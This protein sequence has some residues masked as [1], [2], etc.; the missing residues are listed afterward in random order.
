VRDWRV[1]A[2]SRAVFQDRRPRALLRA[3]VRLAACAALSLV[4]APARA[5]SADELVRQA[6]AHEAAREHDVALRRYAEALAIDPTHPDAWLG[7]GALRLKLGEAAEAERVYAS[8]LERVPS[9]HRALEGRARARWALGRHAE[10]ESDLDAYAAGDGDVAALRELA[11]WYAADG[12]VAAQLATWR[13]VLALARAPGKPAT[14]DQGRGA[15]APG[16]ADAGLE[17]EARR[18]VQALV[19]LVDGADPASSP[20]DPDA[21]R[22]ALARIAL[23]G[24]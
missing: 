6:E 10:A 2:C 4:A 16:A 12:R 7:L 3:L 14:G 24:G 8:A 17:H 13:K 5:S 9:L 22:R 21:T 23:R 18:M 11:G 19:I 20:V 15:E 1:R